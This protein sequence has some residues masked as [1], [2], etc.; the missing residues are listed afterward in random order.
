V[1]LNPPY[2]H[3]IHPSLLFL[4]LALTKTVVVHKKPHT[5][6]HVRLFLSSF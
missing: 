4:V 1:G 5:G 6:N 2:G 3:L